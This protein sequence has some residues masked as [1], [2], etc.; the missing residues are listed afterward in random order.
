LDPRR[1]ATAYVAPA[2]GRAQSA[3]PGD[4]VKLVTSV[5]GAA[6]RAYVAKLAKRFDRQGTPARLE[7]H[8][9]QPLITQD[10][11][12]RKLDTEPVVAGIVHALSTNTRLALGFRTKAIKPALTSSQ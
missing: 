5:H 8:S 7:L 4:N 1:F 2:I 6:L 11:A 10:H 9:G 3:T 12:G